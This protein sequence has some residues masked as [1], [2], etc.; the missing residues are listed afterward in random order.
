LAHVGVECEDGEVKA[1]ER[2]EEALKVLEEAGVRRCPEDGEIRER[3]KE[4]AKRQGVPFVDVSSNDYLGYAEGRDFRVEDAKDGRGWKKKG[5]DDDLVSRETIAPQSEGIE[6]HVESERDKF[7]ETTGGQPRRKP[8]QPVV[9]GRG[10]TT[11][12]QGAGASRLLGGSYVEHVQLESMLADWMQQPAALLFASGYAA[13]VGLLSSLPQVDDIVF[14]DSLNH[15]SIIDGCRLGPAEVAVYPHRD[16]AKLNALLRSRSCRG[17]RWVVTETYFSMDGDGPDLRLLRKICN[18]NGVGL[19]VDEAH[20]LGVFGPQGAGL[21]AAQGITPDVCM[22]AFGKSVGLQGAFV[23]GPV[24]L[25]Q[26][27]WNKARSFVYS[28][29]PSPILADQLLLHVKQIRQDDSARTRLATVVARVRARIRD[30]GLSLGED[31]FGPILPLVI[32]DNHRTLAVA[33]YLRRCGIL[34]FPVRP[35]TVPSGTARLRITLTASMSD[36]ALDHLLN[37]LDYCR[38][39]L[40]D[41]ETNL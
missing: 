3:V 24:V 11:T 8:S 33:E 2:I 38:T 16:L 9:A 18:D 29:A 27:L 12:R 25:K 1:F 30:L 28:T 40:T 15:A 35:P 34:V 7:L 23:A 17:Q 31:S 6:T 13:N 10:R 20:A 4:I 37:S 39:L 26:W 32:G 41:S 19:I 21:A 5:T 22:G 36:E 14:S